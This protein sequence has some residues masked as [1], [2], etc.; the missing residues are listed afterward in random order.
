MPWPCV[1]FMKLNVECERDF[2]YDEASFYSLLAYIWEHRPHRP[3]AESALACCYNE[4]NCILWC[5]GMS[6]GFTN[7]LGMLYHL[8][9]PSLRSLRIIKRDST[10]CS[11]RRAIRYLLHKV[12]VFGSKIRN[13]LFMV[14]SY[15]HTLL[16]KFYILYSAVSPNIQTLKLHTKCLDVFARQMII[17]SSGFI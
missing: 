2:M 1:N 9:V 11:K 15:F 12:V 10:E 8:A 5:L 14:V 7:V 13:S 17:K 6:L 4:T 16:V 3:T